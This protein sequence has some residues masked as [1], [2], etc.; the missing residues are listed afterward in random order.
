MNKYYKKISFILLLFV[1]FSGFSQIGNGSK[2]IL[3]WNITGVAFN[4]INLQYERLITKRISLIIG[5]GY[6][7]EGEIP[8][9]K[10]LKESDIQIPDELLIAKMSGL[11][12]NLESRFYLGQGYGQGFYIS[13]YYRY[14]EFN[15]NN[16]IFEYDNNHNSTNSELKTSAHNLGILLGSQWYLDK[17]KKWVLDLWILGLHYGR[18]TGKLLPD[19]NNLSLT[20]EDQKN[21]RQKITNFDIPLTSMETVEVTSKSFLAK[22]KGPWAGIRFGVSVGYRF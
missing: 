20:D 18:G 1:S 7:I 22:M 8:Y 16:I 11:L 6:I 19:N 5:A 21:L 12:F 13:P 10:T 3:K 17:S 4:N 15:I 14:S 2:D 9:I